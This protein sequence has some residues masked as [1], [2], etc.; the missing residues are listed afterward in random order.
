MR[1]DLQAALEALYGAERRRDRL[2]L[3]GT[4]ALM[5]SLGHPERSFRAVH[6]AGTNGKG[7]VCARVERVLRAAGHRVG[8]YTSPHL[9]DFRERIRVDGRWADEAWLA[10]TLQRIAAF[11]DR[12]ERTFF[13]VATALGFAWF[14]KQQVELAVVE[15]GLGGRL[16]CTNV[17][18]PIVTAITSIGLDHTEILGDSIEKIASE[19][20]GIVKPGVPVVIGAGMDLVAERVIREVARERRAEVLRAE[21]PTPGGADPEVAFALE[22]LA[23]ARAILAALRRA[24]VSIPAAA[25]REGLAASRWPGRLEACPDEPRLLWDGAHNPHGITA[26]A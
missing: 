3:E 5:R 7:S 14:A 12:D 1:P 25:E 16:D 2:G 20:A 19:K 18:S 6:V 24:D 17:V 13:E 9:V 22:N 15:V 10:A 23:T 11:P 26:L 8:L 21:E 4:H